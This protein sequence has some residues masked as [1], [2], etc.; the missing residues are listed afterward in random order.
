MEE[1]RT[2]NPR[3]FC[4]R[5]NKKDQPC[6]VPTLAFDLPELFPNAPC[7]I[8]GGPEE[9]IFYAALK[10]IHDQALAQGRAHRPEIKVVPA[11]TVVIPE[12]KKQPVLP[13]RPGCPHPEKM[14]R[15]ASADI[16][17]AHQYIPRGATFVVCERRACVLD[18]MAWVERTTGEKALWKKIDS[19]PSAYWRKAPPA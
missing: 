18:V 19:I 15:V 9:L 6:G 16:I 7:S 17:E 5:P 11:Q 4:G 2:P 12:V 13:A 14:Y 8:H 10:E 1:K 3:H